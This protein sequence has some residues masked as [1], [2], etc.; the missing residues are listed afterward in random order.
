MHQHETEPSIRTKADPVYVALFSGF[1]IW[2]AYDL[3]RIFVALLH[4]VPGTTSQHIWSLLW[5][6]GMPSLVILLAKRRSSPSQALSHTEKSLALVAC[7]A[8]AANALVTGTQTLRALPITIGQ[9]FSPY[10]FPSQAP[11][12]VHEV[13]EITA[14][15]VMVATLNAVAGATLPCVP[16]VF[17][18]LCAILA[19][20]L[21]RASPVPAEQAR[22]WLAVVAKGLIGCAI[23]SVAVTIWQIAV[24][25]TGSL[26][27]HPVAPRTYL[28]LI[29][30]MALKVAIVYL[31]AGATAADR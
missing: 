7:V 25:W 2:T 30:S 23:L 21:L 17:A 11:Q 20:L 16:P 28:W 18:G 29:E 4:R 9:G 15:E 19:W 1:L 3:W 24:L 10:W 27:P 14:K 22:N 26:P 12:S 8:L 13:S 31:A 6:L 5:L